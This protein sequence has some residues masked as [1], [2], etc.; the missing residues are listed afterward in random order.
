[1]ND[2]EAELWLKAR[3]GRINRLKE[4]NVW[5][6]KL[7]DVSIG[8]DKGS[9]YEFVYGHGDTLAEAVESLKIALNE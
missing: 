6:S 7:Y 1:M 3:N 2:A 9:T 5:R 8:C 4:L